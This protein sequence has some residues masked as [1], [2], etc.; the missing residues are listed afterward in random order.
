MTAYRTDPHEL[1]TSDAGFTVN[2]L[3]TYGDD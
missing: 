2:P 3:D 1:N